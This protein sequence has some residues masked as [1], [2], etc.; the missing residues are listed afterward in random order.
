MEM[1]WE[2]DE[3]SWFGLTFYSVPVGINVMTSV[4]II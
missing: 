4:V 3:G 1:Y 2:K